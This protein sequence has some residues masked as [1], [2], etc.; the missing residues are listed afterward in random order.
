MSGM[1]SI[2]STLFSR[3]QQRCVLSLSVLQQLVQSCLWVRLIQGLAWVGL[4][5]DFSV[6]GGFG[7][8]GST[9]AKLLKIWKDYLKTFKARL[10]KIRLHQAVKFVSCTV[11]G[12]VG[13]VRWWV[14]LDRVTQNG[15]MDNS[16]LIIHRVKWRHII[17]GHDM[18]AYLWV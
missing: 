16:E 10:D 13:S 11:L 9:Q 17:Y 8:F 18:I 7:W 3:W 6:S 5:R 4:G 15:P 1:R 14:G 12:R 2:F